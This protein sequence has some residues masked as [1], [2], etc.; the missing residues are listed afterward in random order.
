MCL[1]YSTEGVAVVWIVTPSIM[2]CVNFVGNI[3]CY[4]YMVNLFYKV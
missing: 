4:G 1:L 2:M 3:L